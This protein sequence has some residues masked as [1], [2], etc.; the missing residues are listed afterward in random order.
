MRR[1]LLISLLPALAAPFLLSAQAGLNGPDAG[2][3][4]DARAAA[5]RQIRGVPGAAALGEVVDA[6]AAALAAWV[7]PKQDVALVNT[8]AGA[9]LVR[10][11]G[12]QASPIAMEE[13]LGSP[14]R[15]VFS[16]SGSTV[17][18]LEGGVVRVWS[19]LAGA[20]KLAASYDVPA[21][22]VVGRA[23]ARP[24]I[25][26]VFSLAVSDDGGFLLLAT[27]AGVEI[28]GAAGDRFTLAET[29]ADARV[30]F[31]P[32]GYD[33]A[34]AAA[35]GAITL[36]RDAAHAPVRTQL[37]TRTGVSAL[38]F[39]ADGKT[40][41]AAMAQARKLAAFDLATGAEST[42]ECGFAITALEP[43]GA[44]FRL[45]EG[46]AQPLWLL[47]TRTGMDVKFVPARAE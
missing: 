14:E 25:P 10:L 4:F 7:A 28:R 41:V 1:S 17:A 5:L 29:G 39:S 42:A 34:F 27:A 20:P 30:A 37:P 9:R 11:H 36:V 44:L 47:D 16:P 40:L 43:M 21:N 6:G 8:A 26:G 13:G 24:V 46:G 18:L 15:V 35:N 45:N 31:A 33:A 2:Y 3:A 12:A 38:A 19:G 22:R 23:G 32:N